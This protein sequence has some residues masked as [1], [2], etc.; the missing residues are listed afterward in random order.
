MQHALARE[1]GFDGWQALKKSLLEHDGGAAKSADRDARI[2]LFLEYACPDHHVR[3]GPAHTRAR[4]AALRMLARYPEIAHDTFYTAVVCGELE[5]VARTLADDPAAA[6]R[7]APGG[8]Q[9]RAGAGYIGD[10]FRDLG[11]KTWEPLL[12]HSFTRLPIA[13][14]DENSVAIATALLDSGADPNAYF[15]AGSSR[16]TPLVGVIGEGEED[17]PPHPRRDALVRLLLDR[18]ADPYD[19]QVLYNIHFHGDILWYLRLAYEY[20]VKLGRRPDWDDPDWNML[21]MGGYGPGAHY[22]LSVAVRHNDL[23]AAKWMLSHGASPNLPT[24]YSHPKFQPQASLYEIAAHAG[25]TEMAELL[26]THGAARVPITLTGIEEFTAACL[27]LDRA[28]ASRL[29]AEHP[30]FLRSTAAAFAA[31]KDNRVD[32]MRLLLDLGV[33]PNV[34]DENHQRPL[35]MAA[36]SDAVDVGRLLLERGADVDP[37]EQNWGGTPLGSANYSQARG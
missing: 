1:H 22:L 10:E 21:G 18:G 5:E 11:R 31:A 28:T 33:S 9:S 8:D 15:M 26:A 29:S 23:A 17:R 24:G 16:Y 13:A 7:R 4:H 32:V 34:E 25:R 20:S 14:V 12:F 27:R 3:G 6:G 35:H 19:I 30:E 2:A 36:W 37:V